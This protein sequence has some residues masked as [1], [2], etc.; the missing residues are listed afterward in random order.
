MSKSSTLQ[1][2]DTAS[3]DP[4]AIEGEIK[5]LVRKASRDS[6]DKKNE[7]FAYGVSDTIQRVTFRSAAEI[8]RLIN[9]LTQLRTR[10]QDESKRVQG[11]IARVQSEIAMYTQTSDAAIQSIKAIDQSLRAVQPHYRPETE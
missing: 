4:I 9:E 11:E 10:L 6:A 5:E 8:D 3:V 7:T 1:P 2:A